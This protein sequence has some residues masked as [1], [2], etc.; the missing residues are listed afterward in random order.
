MSRIIPLD[1]RP[2]QGH[3]PTYYGDSVGHWEGDA[4]VIVS[5]NFKRWVLD[6]Y[7]YTDPKE[8]RMMTR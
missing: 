1:G 7:F 6:D 8:Y 5:T 2:F 4:L 3:R